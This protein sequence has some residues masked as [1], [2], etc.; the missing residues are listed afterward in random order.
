MGEEE[1]PVRTHNVFEDN[2]VAA[3]PEVVEDPINKREFPGDPALH[4]H[5]VIEDCTDAC[6]IYTEKTTGFTT[7][8]EAIRQ[9]IAKKDRKES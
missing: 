2:E 3:E 6:P 1:K 8:E 9:N 4:N 5:S 7:T